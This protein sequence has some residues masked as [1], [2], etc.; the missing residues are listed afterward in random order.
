MNYQRLSFL[1]LLVLTL[2]LIRVAVIPQ[3]HGPY[4]Y[5]DEIVY[6]KAPTIY[7]MSIYEPIPK[8]FGYSGAIWFNCVICSLCSIPIFYLLR[9]FH[10]ER[11]AALL[12]VIV[13]LYAPLWLYSFTNMTE[14]SIFFVILNTALLA[15]RAFNLKFTWGGI[16]DNLILAIPCA[17]AVAIK[18]FG[19]T[20]FASKVRY[21]FFLALA[22]GLIYIILRPT[23]GLPLDNLPL[24]LLR[25]AMYVFFATLGFV[26]FP[27][28]RFIKGKADVY[29]FQALSF[30]VATLALQFAFFTR[31]Q[32]GYMYGRYWDAGILLILTTTIFKQFDKDKGFYLLL[33]GLFILAYIYPALHPD[34][35]KMMDA[36]L[37]PFTETLQRLIIKV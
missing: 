13:S 19:F 25:G 17:I 14:A 32:H 5:P 3:L 33:I 8:Y 10:S 23:G 12:T 4:I 27:I 20:L 31:L 9:K 16:T 1:V 7:D 2:F 6:G 36:G 24:S 21:G 35:G 28:W 11:N 18:P 34:I 15:E 22:A 26:A 30:L 37:M 29:D